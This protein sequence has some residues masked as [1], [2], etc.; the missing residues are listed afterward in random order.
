MTEQEEVHGWDGCLMCAVRALTMG[1][2]IDWA[3]SKNREVGDTVTGVV[4]KAGVQPSHYEV[5]VPYLDLWLGGPYR[6]RIAGHGMSLR[7]ALE[8]IEAEVGDTVTV[9]FTE[10]REIQTGKYK[11]NE[12]KVFDV[13]V[14]RGHH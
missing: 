3:Q 7:N 1:R 4:L 12:F 14:K 5:Q 6:V 11:G 10:I 13:E 8:A 2:P 9:T